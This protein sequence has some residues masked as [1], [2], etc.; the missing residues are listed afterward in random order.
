MAAGYVIAI[1]IVAI[2]ALVAIRNMN[3]RKQLLGITS[4]FFTQKRF[5][6]DRAEY[7]SNNGSDDGH[8]RPAD[9]H[10]KVI[11]KLEAKANGQHVGDQKKILFEALHDPYLTHSLGLCKQR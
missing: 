5:H 2:G 1:L 3:R 10:A 7:R 8:D 9:L 4:A 6:D 11:A